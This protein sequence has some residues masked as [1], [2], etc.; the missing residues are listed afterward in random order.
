MDV[1]SFIERIVSTS[2]ALFHDSTLSLPELNRK[3]S[4]MSDASSHKEY[5]PVYI[6]E[7]QLAGEMIR[8]FL[9]SM[10][11]PSLLVQESAGVTFGLTVGPMGEVQVYVP[12]DRVAEAKEV[13]KAMEEGQLEDT[14]LADDSAELE[15]GWEDGVE[16]GEDSEDNH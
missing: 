15:E 9:E 13:L 6:A 16:P 5:V 12:A 14:E 1:S 7:G 4:Y 2:A 11:I 8:M 10:G 3:V